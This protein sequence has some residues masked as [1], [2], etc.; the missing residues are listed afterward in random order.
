VSD[1]RLAE[2]IE[3]TALRRLQNAYADVV[4]RRAWPELEE[5][6]VP[7]ATIT[8]DTRRGDPMRFEGPRALGEFIGASIERFAFFEFVIL[9]T[10]LD[11]DVEG[12]T[13]RGRMYM[14]E[15][16]Q[17]RDSG[18]WTNAFGLYQDRF[19]RDGDRWWFQSRQYHSLARTAPA[20]EVF[21]FPH[22]D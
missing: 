7:D 10:W 1:A 22:V 3:Y 19:R 6:F 20:N 5:L 21:A 4:T 14:C 2:T 15:L 11:I 18:Q 12:G 13:A 16:R 9:N 17:D 8:V